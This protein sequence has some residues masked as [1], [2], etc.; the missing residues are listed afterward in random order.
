M[1]LGG[2]V[3][4]EMKDSLDRTKV[5]LRHLPPAISQ[6]ALT[7]Q[8]DSAFAG[9][10]HWLTFRPGKARFGVFIFCFGGNNLFLVLCFCQWVCFGV[11][12]VLPSCSIGNMNVC[13]CKNVC[14]QSY[15]FT[16]FLL[17]NGFGFIHFKFWIS[18]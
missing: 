14:M 1:F 8:I 15:V 17:I 6:A 2:F 3:N 4:C 9:R 13:V 10:Y 11:L 7:D 16:V 5:V 18:Y 12:T